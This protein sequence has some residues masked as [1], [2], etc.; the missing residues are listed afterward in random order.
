LERF[1]Y[2]GKLAS[3]ECLSNL[4]EGS[5]VDDQEQ[6]RPGRKAQSELGVKS[7]LAEAGL[8]KAEIR[9][10][11]RSLG[12]TVW[13]R[14]SSPC[15]ATRFP[16]GMPIT[17]E[18]LTRVAAAENYLLNCGFR[19]VRVRDYGHMARIEVDPE[20]I[21]QLCINRYSLKNKLLDL[22][23]KHIALDLEGYRSGSM[24]EVL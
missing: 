3:Q 16:Y 19:S 24:D 4:L 7:P 1:K 9:A 13:D 20:M 6:R 18:G 21:D 2:L 22:G 14:P 10:L 15:L 12:L 11:S 17:R 8:R 23:Y 5:N